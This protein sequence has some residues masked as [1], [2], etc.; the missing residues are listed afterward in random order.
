M[1]GL[2]K[3]FLE[4]WSGWD[5]VDTFSLQF[6]KSVF[7]RNVGIPDSIIDK[8]GDDACFCIDGE[9]SKIYIYDSNG[10]EIFKASVKIV[11]E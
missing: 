7:K 2:E 6:Y 9:H 8:A 11:I 1:I 4:R 10:V 5:E 3:S